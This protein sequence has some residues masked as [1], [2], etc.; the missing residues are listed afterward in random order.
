MDRRL[1]EPL[2]IATDMGLTLKSLR[3]GKHMVMAFEQAATGRTV[4]A[5]L[6]RSPSDVRSITNFRRDL[7]RQLKEPA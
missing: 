1:R 3:Q 4:T 2:R 6:S 5:T 7:A